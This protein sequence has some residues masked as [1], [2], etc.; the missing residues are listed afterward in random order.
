[1]EG[2][3]LSV[4]CDMGRRESYI[5]AKVI[6][7][8]TARGWKQRKMMFVGRRGCPDRWFFRG[9]GQVVIIEFKDPNGALSTAQRREV[10][11]FLANG[12]HVHVIDSIE[13]GKA[14]FDAWDE[15]RA[16]ADA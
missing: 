8:A 1:M 15:A 6:E 7:Y 14:V 11:W 12:F 9:P 3:E 13:D 4:K 2:A 16:D 5:E 10:N